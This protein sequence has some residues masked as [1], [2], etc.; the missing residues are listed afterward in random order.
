MYLSLRSL[1]SCFFFPLFYIYFSFF[2]N[3]WNSSFILKEECSPTN[4]LH[5]VHVQSTLWGSL[6]CMFIGGRNA[7]G[8]VSLWIRVNG[9]KYK[10]QLHRNI[11]ALGLT[12]L[13]FNDILT[14][15]CFD[16]WDSIQWWLLARWSC[17]VT[18]ST[19]DCYWV[20]SGRFYG[21]PF[22]SYAKRNPSELDLTLY[23]MFWHKLI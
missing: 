22:Y 12:A 19:W 4:S 10:K 21:C 11:L 2:E 23:Y 14:V 18:V 15:D 5:P 16:S 20:W 9:G 3:W 7:D 1:I 17:L 8:K 13:N 6:R